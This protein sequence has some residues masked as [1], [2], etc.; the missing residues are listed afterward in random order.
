MI[1][2]KFFRPLSMAILKGKNWKNHEFENFELKAK[3]GLL[4][5]E[6]FDFFFFY[7]NPNQEFFFNVYLINLIVSKINGDINLKLLN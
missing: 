1:F 7:L 4:I 6:D 3:I 2:N 5:L